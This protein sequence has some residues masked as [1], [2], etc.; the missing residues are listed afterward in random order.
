MTGVHRERLARLLIESLVIVASIL[1][2]FALDR[3]WESV[4]ARAEEQEV[5]EA[6]DAEFRAARDQLESSLALHERIHRSVGFVREELDR[7]VRDGSP[8]AVLPDTA[9]ALLYIPPT[10]QLTLGTLDGLVGSA[11][12]GVIR[13]GELRSSL[14]SWGST[15]DELTEEE[16]A[17]RQYVNTEM[18]RALRARMNVNPFRW[19][20]SAGTLDAAQSG[21][22]SRVPAESEILGVVASR[23]ALLDHGIEEFPPVLDELDRL[24]ELIARSR[25]E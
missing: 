9:L 7:A 23:Y 20:F 17:S 19:V 10:T 14:A 13:N 8:F 24:L 1:A 21:S 18:D 16:W 5:L 3:W 6:L 22:T 11:R 12:L 2:A 25:S 4:R 15:L